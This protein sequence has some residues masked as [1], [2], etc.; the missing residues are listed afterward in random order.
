MGAGR[1]ESFPI[2][3]GAAPSRPRGGHPVPC[4]PPPVRPSAPRLAARAAPKQE[5]ASR[6]LA[7]ASPHP[8]VPRSAPPSP[9]PPFVRLQGT[10]RHPRSALQAVWREHWGDS[11]GVGAGY[12][13]SRRGK[14][15]LSIACLK[16]LC[17]EDFDPWGRPGPSTHLSAGRP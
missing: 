5:R 3:E 14:G 9:P 7:P 1:W 8:E 17:C 15:A 10:R 6:A 12:P 13:R 2:L 16:I 4:L 11:C